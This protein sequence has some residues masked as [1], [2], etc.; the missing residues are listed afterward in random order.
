M[1]LRD[2]YSTH[3]WC[4]GVEGLRLARPRRSVEK[5]DQVRVFG[6][7][8]LCSCSSWRYLLSSLGLGLLL[9]IE[10]NEVVE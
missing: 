4:C 10:R 7:V 2:A 3:C 6:I 8:S 9:I 5:M 1:A